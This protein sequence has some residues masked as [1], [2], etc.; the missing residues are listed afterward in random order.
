MISVLLLGFESSGRQ[1]A[2]PGD[3][4]RTLASLVPATV[5]G[6][7]RDLCLVGPAAKAGLADV[8]DHAGCVYRTAERIPDSIRL[9][10]REL[11]CPC[12][13]VTFAGAVF[14]RPF[15]EELSSLLP[16]LDDA[17]GT[18]ILRAVRHDLIGRVFPS[19]GL[20]AGV[21][22]QRTW[23]E[24]TQAATMDAL[25]RSAKPRRDFK[26]RVSVGP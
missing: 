17:E 10:T 25:A 4:V 21:L 7:V 22:A 3:A 16:T 19:I 1:A 20:V 15:V 11:R 2:T 14:D 5:E 18:Y 6:V 13:L 24:A 12:V 8:A 9:G 23:L 26:T